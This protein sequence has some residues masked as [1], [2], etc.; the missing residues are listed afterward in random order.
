MN[1]KILITIL[2][3]IGIFAILGYSYSVLAE[4]LKETFSANI[5]ADFY[6][7]KLHSD[8]SGKYK[9]LSK[10]TRNSDGHFVYCVQPWVDLTESDEYDIN[11]SNQAEILGVSSDTWKRISQIAYYGYGYGNHTDERWYGITQLMIWQTVDPTGSFYFTK[12]LNGVE[13]NTYDW[14]KNEIENLISNHY[15]TPNFNVDNVTIHIGEEITL[16][17]YNDVLNNFELVQNNNNATISISENKLN[18]TGIQNGSISITLKKNYD[19]NFL[20]TTPFLYNHVN[21]QSIISR[22]RPDPVT[23]NLNINVAGARVNVEKLDS[24]TLLPI[25]RGDGTFKNA[26]YG[27]YTE[28]DERVGQVTIQN[29]SIGTSDYLPKLGRYYLKEEKSSLGY[30]LDTTKYYFE[31]TADNLNPTVKVYET[32]IE[33]EVEIFKVFADG[34]TTILKAEPNITFEFY[35]KSSMELYETAT[36]NEKGRMSVTLPYGVYIVKQVNTTPNYE[37]VQDFEITIDNSS[38]DPITKIISNAGI[39]AKFKLVKRDKDSNK[40]VEKAGIKFRIK[41]LDTD[42]YICQSITYPSQSKICVF[43]TDKSGGFITPYALGLGNYQIEELENQTIDGYLWN[44]TPLK[45]SITKDSNFI[46]D[47]EYGVIL[48]LSFYN[49]QVR[50]ELEINKFGEKLIIENNTFKYEEIKLD[51]VLYN[52][53]ANG[54][55]YSQD[56]TLI[57]EDK[58]LISSFITKD[59]YY[60]ITDMYLGSYCLVEQATVGNHILDKTEHCFS[61]E[62][63][64]QYT[65][66]VLVKLK[67]K[68]YL[69]KGKLDFTKVD[70]TTG[71]LLSNTKIKIYTNNDNEEQQLIF[72][73]KTDDL[74]KIIISNLFISKFIIY[75]SE[76]PENYILN[77]E[78][79]EFEI[80]ENNQI[81]KVTMKNEKIV[82]VPNTS[83]NDSKILD[84]MG[85]IFILSG[86]GYI[87]YDKRK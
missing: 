17:D 61:I 27:I 15:I 60:K 37:K 18:I 66:T 32:A 2:T 24:K 31:I 12:T 26:T 65:K 38:N 84:I 67:L 29:N 87:V 21:A 86:I 3:I 83:I 20:D 50:G 79:T 34:S 11:L 51:G 78:P 85:V 54:N 53:Y 40:V 16:Q 59:G 28:T 7:K 33:R 71:K 8:G 14:M 46:Y 43:E 70:L 57:Y 72:E 77:L 58:E 62:Y 19:S 36:T 68:N 41:N 81:I 47:D 30:Q 52:L 69:Q 45:F 39:S 13:D 35:L 82:E 23:I 44:S 64:D 80:R 6:I 56:G 49:E 10:I 63:K 4:N 74:G 5:Y 22:G 9:K 75:E 73:G 48:E 42:E 25:P 76:A 1:K 55:I